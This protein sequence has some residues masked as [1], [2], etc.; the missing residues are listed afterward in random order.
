L[1]DDLVTR[2]VC[3]IDRRN[4]TSR[5]R[6]GVRGACASRADDGTNCAGCANQAG[7]SQSGRGD[8]ACRIPGG[9]TCGESGGFTGQ[10]YGP[11]MM[12]GYGMITGW[13]VTAA[14][15]QPINSLDEAT[16]AFQRFIGATG[17]ANL[18][19]DDVIQFQWNHYAIMKDTSTRQGAFELL[20]DPWTG[21]VFPE[22]G[23]NMM[24]NTKHG[25]MAGSGRMG[26]YWPQTAVHPTVAADQAQQ[27]AQQW[28]D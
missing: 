13:G 25:H 22:M 19:L 23:P 28:L 8:I 14:Q 7:G 2:L 18:A 20:A 16:Q 1:V 26:S 21:A 5:H 11:G 6:C 3:A 10:G 9:E 12:R 24:W 4:C 27:I 17:K 15:A